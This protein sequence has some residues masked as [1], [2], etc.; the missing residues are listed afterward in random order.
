MI[1][2]NW[3]KKKKKEKVPP[4]GEKEY[5]FIWY[6]E[7][8]TRK[9]G[10]VVYTKPFRTRVM[11]KSEDEAKE[12]LTNFALSKMKLCIVL[13]QDFDKTEL[14]KIQKMFDDTFQQMNDIVDRIKFN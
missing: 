4:Q 10:R 8:E 5:V 13:E 14:S 12:K 6:K 9:G 2:F 1:W 11:A 3:K 7:I